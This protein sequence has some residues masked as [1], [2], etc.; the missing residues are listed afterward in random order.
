M[1]KSAAAAAGIL[2]AVAAAGGGYIWTQHAGQAELREAVER[3][4]AGLGPNGSFSYVSAA[5]HPFQ[6]STD[7]SS[8]AVRTSSGELFTAE[9]ITFVVAGDGSLSSVHATGLRVS[10]SAT[11]GTLTATA[12]DGKD[13]SVPRPMTGVPFKV[14]PA[15]VM[16]A[17]MTVR[18]LVFRAPGASATIASIEVGDYGAG[19]PSTLAVSSFSAPL[20]AAQQIDHIGFASL[21]VAGVD[22]ASAINALEH[23]TKLPQLSTGSARFEL[24]GFYGAA[25]TTRPVSVQRASLVGKAGPDG[26]SS[27]NLEIM[28]FSMEPLDPVVRSQLEDVGLHKING[29][30]SSAGS[31][32]IA[33]GVLEMA[34]SIEVDGLGKL[35]FGVKAAHVDLSRIATPKP[36]FQALL[37]IAGDARIMSANADFA[38]GGLL[39]L[40]LATGAR[41]AGVPKDQLRAQA[42]SLASQNPTFAAVPNGEQM[43]A[44]VV[45]FLKHGGKLGIAIRPPSPMNVFEIMQAG[46]SGPHE[47]VSR[48]GLSIHGD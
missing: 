20:P 41:T 19:R 29:N 5:V 17:T 22:F 46:Q 3:I 42:I 31:Y 26:A 12:L 16:F 2:V 37:A 48:V 7:L 23:G 24:D 9:Q 38:D 40:A 14:D 4:Q 43:R 36:D 30:L 10:G 34:P 27:S 1:N 47:L 44:V 32:Q 35:V 21:T 15:A 13:I 28:G 8:V 45:S 11:Q 6:R 25:G 18:D 39:D 33:G